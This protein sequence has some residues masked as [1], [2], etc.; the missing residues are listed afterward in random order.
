MKR[1]CS[2]LSGSIDS[3]Q[4]GRNTGNQTD[5]NIKQT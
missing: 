2:W 5:D 4:S 1:R 3:E